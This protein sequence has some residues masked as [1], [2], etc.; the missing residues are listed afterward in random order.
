MISDAG[1]GSLVR[2]HGKINATVYKEIWRKHVV[3]NLRT[4]VNHPAVFMQYNAP[5]HT[6]KS[7]KTFLSEERVTVMEWPAPNP[8][9]NMFGS[10]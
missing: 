3:S 9:M 2:L 6:A 5:C 1:T 7:I 10:F 8:V 4:A